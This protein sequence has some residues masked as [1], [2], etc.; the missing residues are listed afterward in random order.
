M[1]YACLSVCVVMCNP[2]WRM[3]GIVRCEQ[4]VLLCECHLVSHEVYSDQWEAFLWCPRCHHLR[5]IHVVRGLI[6]LRIGRGIFDLCVQPNVTLSFFPHTWE[7][8]WKGTHILQLYSQ[9]LWKQLQFLVS[10]WQQSVHY[11]QNLSKNISL[12]NRSKINSKLWE[13]CWS[14]C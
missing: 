9:N 1:I 4:E 5:Y 12:M 7:L 2:P 11:S 6:G 14:S 3:R 13:T 8:V 10:K